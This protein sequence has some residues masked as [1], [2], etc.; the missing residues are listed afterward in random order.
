MQTYRLPPT[1]LEPTR[2]GYGCM[3]IGRR[4]DDSPLTKEDIDHARTAVHTALNAGINFFDHADIYTMGKSEQAFAH[5]LKEDPQLRDEIIIQS[6]C[7]IRFPNPD[8]GYPVRYDFSYDYIIQSVDG[9]L[10]RLQT[11]F[12]DILLLHR[13]DP[14][15][16]PDEVARAFDDLHASGKVRHFGVSN[17][18]PSQIALLQTSLNQPLVVNQI[19]LSLHHIDP[20][21]AGINANQYGHP[22]TGGADIINYCRQHKI[23]IQAWGSLARGNLFR[24]T[25]DAPDHHQELT[26]TINDLAK[27]KNCSPEALA[28]AWLLRHPAPIQPIIGTTNPKRI[29]ACAEADN[30]TLSREEWYLLLEKARGAPAP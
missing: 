14:L 25:A 6:K 17:H 16:E 9:I 26:N 21:D 8:K 24:P 3:E 12:L 15:M 1:D 22:Y 20:I 2:L 30:V 5:L 7:A 23:L 4:W 11:P 27:I 29:E 13:P 18:T 10:D 28:L 19:Q